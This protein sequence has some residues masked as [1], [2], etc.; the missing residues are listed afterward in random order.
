MTKTVTKGT[1]A[2]RAGKPIYCPKCNAKHTVFNFRWR[3]IVCQH[4]LS[5]LN[6]YECLLEPVPEYTKIL[7][8]LMES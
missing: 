3:T 8:R 5:L 6:K 1:R 2:G 7:N 4:C